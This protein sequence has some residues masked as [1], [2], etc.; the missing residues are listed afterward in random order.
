V[1]PASVAANDNNTLKSEISQSCDLKYEPIISMADPTKTT[2][3]PGPP[4]IFEYKVCVKGIVESSISTQCDTTTGFIYLAK[5]G[6]L[7]FQ[8]KTA[9][10]GVFVQVECEPVYLMVLL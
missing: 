9:T 5:I 7:I 10:T 6:Q 2:S 3:N 4:D 1:I 8:S